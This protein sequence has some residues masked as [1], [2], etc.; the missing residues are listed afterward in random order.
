MAKNDPKTY[1]EWKKGA[2]NH[3]CIFYNLQQRFGQGFRGMPT[4]PQ[5]W[6]KHKQTRQAD[7]NAMDMS[8]RIK[9]CA[10]LTNEEWD[11][12]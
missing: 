6:P 2:V 12:L 10:T 4:V 3:N 5:P 1:E 9:T 11:K 7:P 8:W